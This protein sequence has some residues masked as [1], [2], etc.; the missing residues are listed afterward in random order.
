MPCQ[1][2]KAENLKNLFKNLRIVEWGEIPD[3]DMIINATS[4]GLKE[5]DEINFFMM[6]FIIQKKQIF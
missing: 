3:F 2:L 5:R 6:L 1:I 4:L